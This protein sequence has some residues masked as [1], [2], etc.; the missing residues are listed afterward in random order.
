MSS[1]GAEALVRPMSRPDVCR[2]RDWSRDWSEAHERFRDN[3]EGSNS[4]VYP[5]LAD[6]TA[7]LFGLC[8]VGVNGAVY[9]SGEWD[10]VLDHERVEAVRVRARL[11]VSARRPRARR[12]QR[13]RPAVQR[14]RGNRAR[15][16]RADQSDG[17]SWRDRRDQPRP[18][19]DGR[20]TMAFIAEGLSRFAGRTLAI[21]DDVFA[22][23]SRAI[24]ATRRSGSC[25]TATDRSPSTRPTRST[26]IRGNARST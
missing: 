1:D 5:A 24:R 3:R 17:Q 19:L 13:D 22:C 6:A 21:D 4:D 20:R 25:F 10:I 8:V 2:R 14:A 12:R 7:D 11:R 15:A 16:G 23:A 9:A 26:S 18:R